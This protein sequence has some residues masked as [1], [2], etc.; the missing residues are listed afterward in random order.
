MPLV[1]HM[2]MQG[3]RIVT[4]DAVILTWDGKSP[5]VLNVGAESIWSKEIALYSEFA[6]SDI[7]PDDTYEANKAEIP[8]GEFH[9]M[10]KRAVGVLL[11]SAS[12]KS[13]RVKLLA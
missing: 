2:D 11:R 12:G 3:E 9:V 4:N 6:A 7:E 13:N 8:G 5:S 10:S 1:I